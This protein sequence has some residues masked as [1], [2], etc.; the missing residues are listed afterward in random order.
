[1]MIN[2][3]AVKTQFSR[4]LERVA[5]GEEVVIARAGKP[6]ALAGAGRAQARAA[7]ARIGTRAPP[8]SPRISTVEAAT[9][10]VLAAQESQLKAAQNHRFHHPHLPSPTALSWTAEPPAEGRCQPVATADPEDAPAAAST[11]LSPPPRL[12][13]TCLQPWTDPAQAGDHGR[14]EAT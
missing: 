2:V 6:V 8:G 14:A 5:Q 10:V 11:G 12:R 9:A 4:L 1:M 7:P 13:R 3:H